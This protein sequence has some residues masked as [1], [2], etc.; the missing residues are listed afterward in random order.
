V[1][2]PPVAQ[3]LQQPPGSTPQQPSNLQ[4]PP[5]SQPQGPTVQPSANTTGTPGASP[6]VALSPSDRDHVIRTI[7]GE[8]ANEP[9]QGQEAVAHVIRNRV[10]T[11][12]WGNSATDVVLAPSQFEPWNTAEGRA[13]MQ[14]LSS[15][16]AEYQQIGALVD[17]VFAGQSADMT[18]GATHFFAPAAQAALGRDVPDWA[19][20]K[21]VTIGGHE[22]YAPNGP[23]HDVG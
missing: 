5:A 12:Q 21:L 8:A 1:P 4:Q 16:S 14:R 13:R 22:F 2:R 15:D 11:G 20:N 19:G 6:S 3:N 9:A 17:R 7:W 23:A 10:L 18:H